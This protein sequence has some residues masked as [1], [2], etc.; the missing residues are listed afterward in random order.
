[1]AVRAAGLGE[2]NS[3]VLGDAGSVYRGCAIV[4]GASV[5]SSRARDIQGPGEGLCFGHNS[6]DD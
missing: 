3:L 5:C 4:T 2:G 6:R 1:M